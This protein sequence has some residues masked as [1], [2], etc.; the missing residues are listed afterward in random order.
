M[1]DGILHDYRDFGNRERFFE[2]IECAQLRRLYR[3]LDA[4]VPGNYHHDRTVG[5]RDLLDP[6]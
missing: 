4:A 1:V 2:E 5:R 3:R 6:R